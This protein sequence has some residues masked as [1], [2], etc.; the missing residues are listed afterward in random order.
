MGNERRPTAHGPE[1][2]AALTRW[3]DIEA[4]VEE[5]RGSAP[6]A[7]ERCLRFLEEDP[8]FH[9][10]GYLKEVIWRRLTHAEVAPRDRRRQEAV[11]L[12]YLE[13]RMTREFWCMARAMAEW[14]SAAF[15]DDVRSVAQTT[16]RAT[17]RRAE[18]MLAYEHGT[19]VGEAARH[20]VGRQASSDREAQRRARK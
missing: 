2:A 7:I 19:A 16:D 5:L 18:T 4:A 12:R 10:S 6:G 14:G 15:W 20:Q 17:R 3:H 11:A 9:G 8:N 1:A 13:R